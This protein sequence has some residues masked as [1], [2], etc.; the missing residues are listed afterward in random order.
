MGSRGDVYLILFLLAALI[1]GPLVVIRR[2][3]AARRPWD[4]ARIMDAPAPK[5]LVR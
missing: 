3:D 1:A 4:G 2:H 5:A